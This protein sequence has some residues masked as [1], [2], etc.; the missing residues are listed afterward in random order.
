M[1]DD[2][3]IE[4]EHDTNCPSCGHSPIRSCRCRNLGCED[5][6]IDRYDE[7]PLWYDED[8][9]EICTECWGTGVERWCP[10]CGFDLQSARRTKHALDEG[11]KSAPQALSTP[12]VLSTEEAESNPALR[13]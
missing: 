8:D 6:W 2:D 9:P 11:D 5:G 10:K 12:E 7:D 4:D 3:E 1:F 13:Q